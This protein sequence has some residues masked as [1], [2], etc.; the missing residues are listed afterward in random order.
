MVTKTSPRHHIFITVTP[1][2]APEKKA[3]CEGKV[4]PL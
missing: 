3:G 1:E 4:I 2:I